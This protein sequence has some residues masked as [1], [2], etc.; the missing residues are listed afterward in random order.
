M[1][2]SSSSSS[3]SSAQPPQRA[4]PE[5]DAKMYASN[6]L[7][8]P[9]SRSQAVLK[10]A[11]EFSKQA[12]Q[13][14]WKHILIVLGI[15]LYIAFLVMATVFYHPSYYAC[16]ARGGTLWSLANAIVHAIFMIF[17]V[18]YM[19]RQF[20]EESGDGSGG[21]GGSGSSSGGLDA[22]NSPLYTFIRGF[23]N[24]L[25]YVLSFCVT[26]LLISYG[27]LFFRCRD[28]PNCPG[29]TPTQATVFNSLVI[30][31][32]NRTTPQLKAL[33]EFYTDYSKS[34]IM[35]SQCQ[36]FY[37][38]SYITAQTA[39]PAS[40]TRK[41][42]T[43]AAGGTGSDT[44]ADPDDENNAIPSIIAAQP[45]VDPIKYQNG[46]PL[47]SQFYVMTSGRTC[48]VNHQY[49]SYMSPAM[50]KIALAGGARCL[51]FEVTNY[52]YTEKS[53]PIV[54]HSRNR[55]NKNLQHNFVLFE[56]VLRTIS[57]EWIEPH[58]DSPFPA[59]PLFIRLVLDTA[60]T[61]NSM[62]QMAYLLQYYFNEQNGQYLLP[63]VFNYKILEKSN[64]GLGDYPLM[65]YCDRIT[66][67]VYS[68]CKPV[69]DSFQKS[70]LHELTNALCTTPASTQSK[71]GMTAVYST[72]DEEPF[73]VFN[74]KTING[75]MPKSGSSSG[76]SGSSGIPAA[77]QG[78]TTAELI[79]E[80]NQL[81]LSYVQT[82]FAPYTP[83]VN[84]EPGNGCSNAEFT[85]NDSDTMTTLLMN[86]LTI[87]NSPVPAF[88]AGCQ[89]IAMNFQDISE[90]MKTYL[91]VFEQ[92]S[93]ILKPSNLWNTNKFAPA[94]KPLTAC[95]PGE[96]SYV[97]PDTSP[98]SDGTCY[99]F[100]LSNSQIPNAGV[101]VTA[102]IQNKRGGSIPSAQLQKLDTSNSCI[103]M[104]YTA[105][106]GGFLN[107]SA[108]VTDTTT[109]K[110]NTVYGTGYI[111]KT[112]PDA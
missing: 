39:N 54:T 5:S 109:G 63:D 74:W 104:D 4:T 52:A 76:S 44:V 50:I 47:L 37:S 26:Y 10:K 53:F 16:M 12:S 89:F 62:D 13:A 21:N 60:L 84:L 35:I 61:Q 82:S 102:T 95:S 43:G 96:V 73:K 112:P 86:K 66:I 28:N 30:T 106:P 59:D 79:Q 7:V 19:V 94:P 33:M 97:Y 45:N 18:F 41:P 91:S 87:N 48:T 83:Y 20:F 29:C 99:E 1:R 67:L 107:A 70:M 110:T 72:G 27:I 88:S 49:D 25:P 32:V 80:Y 17:L 108:T 46:A 100:C 75:W 6:T 42:D 22:D 81:G 51:D 24:I 92:S 105:V 3:A 71:Q 85:G 11:L 111:K 56:D 57:N 14:M 58:Q 103:K 98:G 40:C 90:Y 9:P 78:T 55:D 38:N 101:P 77:D 23:D 31:Q 65:F 36:N 93:F 2:A 8:I 34:R 68:P 64:T 69:T 15:M